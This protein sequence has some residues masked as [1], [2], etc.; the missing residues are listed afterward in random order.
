VCVC[1]CVCVWDRFNWWIK[2]RTPQEIGR[3]CKTLAELVEKE[4]EVR[5]SPSGKITL[6]C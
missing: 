3:R 4:Y 5:L 6:G 1:V 2:S